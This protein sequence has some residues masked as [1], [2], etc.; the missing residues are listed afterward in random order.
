MYARYNKLQ[1]LLKI[2]EMEHTLLIFDN[3]DQEPCKYLP[4]FKRFTLF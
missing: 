4:Y 2:T 3:P 1:K